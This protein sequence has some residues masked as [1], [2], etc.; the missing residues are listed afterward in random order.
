MKIVTVN[1][2]DDAVW[3][4]LRALPL[5]LILSFVLMSVAS[6]A[7]VKINHVKTHVQDDVYYLDANLGYALTERMLEAL[8]K[9]V[10]LT[11]VLNIEVIKERSYIWDAS[12]AKLE[13]RYQLEYLPLTQQYQVRNLNSGALHNLPSLE[14]ALS[15]LGAIVDLP[16]L[17]K[18][19]LVDDDTYQARLRVD[20]DIEEL[21]LPLRLLSYFTDEW[22]LRSEWY[23]WLLQH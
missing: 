22:R 18:D 7:G 10:P 15:V 23:T 4:S 14:V 16:L 19:L 11:F 21:P 3:R 9:S 13:Q 6:A 20:L 1:A 12:V 2:Y 17:D 5:V 8:H